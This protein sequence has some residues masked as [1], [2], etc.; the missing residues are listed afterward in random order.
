MILSTMFNALTHNDYEKKSSFFK[1]LR[2][3]NRM[4]L[5]INTDILNIILDM[6]DRSTCNLQHNG[7]KLQTT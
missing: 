4:A 2:D 6:E 7:S 3:M 1:E 5:Y